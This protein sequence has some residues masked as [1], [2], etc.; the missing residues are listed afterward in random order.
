MIIEVLVVVFICVF[1]ILCYHSYLCLNLLIKGVR[2]KIE[3]SWYL[4]TMPENRLS[5][6]MNP[7]Y[8]KVWRNLVASNLM[9]SYSLTGSL[10]KGIWII[11][12]KVQCK[13]NCW[14]WVWSLIS[15]GL[16]KFRLLL[17][18]LIWCWVSCLCVVYCVG[19][20]IKL[21]NCHENVHLNNVSIH[22]SLWQLCGDWAC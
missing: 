15:F 8:D 21:F 10:V 13:E 17:L 9:E 12:R 5:I 2:W 3:G 16:Y 4:Q 11:P 22:W 1:F 6:M 7:F 18:G 20:I 14:V 19:Y